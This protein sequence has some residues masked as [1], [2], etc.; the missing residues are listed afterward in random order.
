MNLLSSDRNSFQSIKR[1]QYH[2]V[3]NAKKH[4][5]HKMWLPIFEDGIVRGHLEAKVVGGKLDGG[6]GT[7][8]LRLEWA[9]RWHQVVAFE[10][11]ETK[12]NGQ[13]RQQ[14]GS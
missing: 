11:L 14:K 1:M 10:S 13:P 5:E 4:N 12:R 9:S 3:W 7:A 8:F 2:R 6:S